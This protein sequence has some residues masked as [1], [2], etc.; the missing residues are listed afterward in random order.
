M[1]IPAGPTFA[2]EPSITIDED[3]V[4]QGT[5]WA[6]DIIYAGNGTM[7]FN[8]TPVGRC[9]ILS[10]MPAVSST[11]V[12]TYQPAPNAFGQCKFNVTLCVFKLCSTAAPLTI[13]VTP[14]A[15]AVAMALYRLCY[16]K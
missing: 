1:L 13:N 5:Q 10:T 14:G 16:Y 15:A 11:G 9:S 12:L 4:V 3:T 2:A 7:T 8:V 6:T